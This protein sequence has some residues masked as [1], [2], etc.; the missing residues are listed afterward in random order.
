MHR[1]SILQELEIENVDKPWYPHN[2]AL[3]IPRLTMVY[4]ALVEKNNLLLPT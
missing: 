1:F 3:H 4:C 2:A